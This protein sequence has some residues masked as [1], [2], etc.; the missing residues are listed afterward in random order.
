LRANT[1]SWQVRLKHLRKI[2][3]IARAKYYCSTD[4]EHYKVEVLQGVTV[5]VMKNV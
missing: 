1:D 4:F 3:Q 5:K 2:L